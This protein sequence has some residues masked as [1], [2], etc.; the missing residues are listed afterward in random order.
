MVRD[1]TCSGVRARKSEADV[2]CSSCC[3]IDKLQDPRQTTASCMA[4]RWNP[5]ETHLARKELVIQKD[6]CFAEN[7]YVG[8]AALAT[9][10]ISDTFEARTSLTKTQVP[11]DW[12]R[13]E[14]HVKGW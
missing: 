11:D 12:A 13:R 6:V 10:I 8:V 5:Y 1:G 3:L 7:A 2:H 9:V 4:W 14:P